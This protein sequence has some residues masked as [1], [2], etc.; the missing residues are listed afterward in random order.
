MLVALGPRRGGARPPRAATAPE[1]GAWLADPGP[2][3]ETAWEV[4][5][6]RIYRLDLA[7]RAAFPYKATAIDADNASL[8]HP[9]PLDVGPLDVGPLEAGPRDPGPRDPGPLVRAAGAMNAEYD[10]W[11][12]RGG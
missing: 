5:G 10:V 11:L 4:T 6:T 12:N 2:L 1:R 7:K 8:R 9:G 3:S